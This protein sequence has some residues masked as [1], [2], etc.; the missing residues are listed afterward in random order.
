MLRAILVTLTAFALAVPCLAQEFDPPAD[1]SDHR[2]DAHLEDYGIAPKHSAEQ[3][4]EIL[5]LVIRGIP[6][7]EAERIV[8]KRAQEE[9]ETQVAKSAASKPPNE[10]LDDPELFRRIINL[11]DFWSLPNAN[12]LARAW[13]ISKRHYRVQGVTRDGKRDYVEI[14]GADLYRLSEGNCFVLLP[15]LRS[16][17]SRVVVEFDPDNDTEIAELTRTHFGNFSHVP[18]TLDSV[19]NAVAKL[20]EP[21]RKPPSLDAF[22][23]GVPTTTKIQPMHLGVRR[24]EYEPNNS[25]SSRHIDGHLNSNPPS[26]QVAHVHVSENRENWMQVRVEQA[27]ANSSR[28]FFIKNNV[29][30]SKHENSGVGL[31]TSY[32]SRSEVIVHSGSEIP[33]FLGAALGVGTERYV[34]RSNRSRA[35]TPKE[36]ET[37]ISLGGRV[38]RRDKTLIISALPQE[39]GTLRSI[40]ELFNMHLSAFQTTQWRDLTRRVRSLSERAQFNLE[41]ASKL[42][43]EAALSRGDDDVVFLIAH[44]ESGRLYLPGFSGDFL[45]AADLAKLG[46]GDAPNRVVV[47]VSCEAGGVNQAVESFAEAILQNNLARSVFASDKLVDGQQIVDLLSDLLERGKSPRLVLGKSGLI[48]IVTRVIA[49]IRPS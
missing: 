32:L 40:R 13:V 7:H 38:L 34:R 46:R 17:Y 9:H 14:G 5:N 19:S 4:R 33:Q 49:K 43:I 48:Q 25:V 30:N 20:K 31:L 27:E 28:I 10:L 22:L 1:R 15:K 18:I 44:N 2:P 35:K 8:E 16:E 12:Q 41:P 47:L 6:Q 21:P 24:L 26:V 23:D 11:G 37:A 36:I 42:S 29:Q 39:S 45:T 3:K